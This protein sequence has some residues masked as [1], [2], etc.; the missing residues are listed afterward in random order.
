MPVQEYTKSTLPCSILNIKPSVATENEDAPLLVWIP[1]NPGLLYYYQEML[2]HLHSKH[3][4]WEILGVSHAGMTLNAHSNTPIFSLQDQVDHQVEVINNFSHENR[5]IIIM[6][7]SVGAYILQKVCLSD[8]LVGSVRKIGLITPTVMDIH[9]SEM[10]V[11]MTAVL[12]YIPPLAHVVSLLSYIFFYWILSEGLSRFVI[13]KFMGCG[14]TGYQAV[15]S[16][17]I[18]LTHKQFVRQSLG[19]ASQEMKEITTNWEFQD[20]FINYCQEN[21]IFIWFLFS[22]KDHWVADK[23]RTHLSHYYK[24]KIKQERLKIDV[25]DKIPHSFVVKHA[26]YAVDTF[27]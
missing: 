17:R 16:T 4:D 2:Q 25:T 9:T 1:G 27:F 24:D 3:P 5:K 14:S 21:E 13:D 18:L 20:E 26:E 19:L 22:T 10:G 7:H 8:K 12:H 15:L 6:G 11:K 23:T